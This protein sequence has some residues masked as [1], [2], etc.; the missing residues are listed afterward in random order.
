MRKII[1]CIVLASLIGNGDARAQSS[2]SVVALGI[3]TY[4]AG[5]YESAA[6]LFRRALA[7]AGSDAV[8]GMA[9]ADALSYLGAT[10]S[11]RG[12]TAAAARAF[13]QALAIDPRYR[14]D[15]LVFP[16]GVTRVFNNARLTTAYTTVRAPSDTVIAS[17]SRGIALQLF[18]SAPHD[19]VVTI[20]PD[21]GG[22][23]HR[24]YAGPI[25]DS[26]T[27]NWNGMDSTGG[28]P[29]DGANVLHVQS[30]SASVSAVSTVPITVERLQVDTL[31]PPAR[32]LEPRTQAARRRDLS[33]FQGLAIGVIAGA[34]AILLPPLLTDAGSEVQERYFVGG[35][36]GAAGV[37]VFF[38][39][40]HEIRLEAENATRTNALEAWQRAYNEVQNENERRKRVRQLR[41]TTKP[42]T[43]K[44]GDGS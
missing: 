10:E 1:L 6:S 37:F 29:M 40:K 17:G 16:P 38:R 9:R 8:S 41:I 13:V 23:V 3:A 31:V 44:P 24:I 7:I 34:T 39:G 35:V 5:E 32:P 20:V 15:E 26:L 2:S 21:R 19:V 12:D 36:L 14:L 27:V 18:A 28:S 4:R 42:E 25:V 30:R 22:I 43:I 11:F 33:P